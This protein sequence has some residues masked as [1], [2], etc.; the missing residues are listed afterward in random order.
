MRRGMLTVLRRYGLAV[1]LVG[2]AL[3]AV[4]Y[5]TP[6]LADA[7]A[8]V[9]VVAVLLSALYGGLGP[10]LVATV[11]ASLGLTYYVFPPVHSLHI[12]LARDVLKL[13]VFVLVALV[14]G[15]LTVA[16]RRG[17][18][19]LQAL[20]T[21]L[22]NRVRERTAELAQANT[23]LEAEIVEH[24]RAEAE[25]RRVIAELQEALANVK[26]LRGLLPICAWCK[27]VRDDR[28]YWSEVESYLQAHTDTRVSHGICPECFQ[29]MQDKVRG[30]QAAE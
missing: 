24:K 27:K 1:L 3:P 30:E 29:E 4:V 25:K 11:L 16:I 21:D 9:L 12:Q 26:T 5:L 22:E 23:G 8:E 15:S 13:G 19:N 14:T 20:N 10:G 7:P 2:L 28:G 6:I 17:R 18:E